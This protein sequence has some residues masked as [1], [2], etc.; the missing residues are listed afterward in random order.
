M[1]EFYEVS[2]SANKI[3]RHDNVGDPVRVHWEGAITRPRKRKTRITTAWQDGSTV[4]LDHRWSVASVCPPSP[5]HLHCLTLVPDLRPQSFILLIF[6]NAS[7]PPK[8]YSSRHP[9]SVHSMDGTWHVQFIIP[10]TVGKRFL[11]EQTITLG[12]AGLPT[13]T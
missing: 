13:P 2:E 5:A 3:A 11:V 4:K 9:H 10:A 8:C 1:H 6:T 12:L 7:P